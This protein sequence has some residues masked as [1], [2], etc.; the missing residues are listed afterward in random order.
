MN[1]VT[2][3]RDLRGDILGCSA[4]VEALL[5]YPAGTL[6]GT[7][8]LRLIP[9]DLRPEEAQAE[10][11]LRAG[12]TLPPT[13]SHR[14]S[15]TGERVAIYLARSAV[16]DHTGA[17]VGIADTL[18][19]LNGARRPQPVAAAR[20]SAPPTDRTSASAPIDSD[21]PLRPAPAAAR[22]GLWEWDLATDRMHW[23]PDCLALLEQQTAA[24]DTDAFLPAVHPDDRL[25]LRQALERALVDRSDL[26]V[27]FRL[28]LPDGRVRW[29]EGVGRLSCG[30]DGLPGRMVGTVRDI[31]AEHARQQ[32]VADSE[33]WFRQLAEGLPQITFAL[34]DR[35]EVSFVS[36]RGLEY[37]GYPS[38]VELG[39]AWNETVHPEDLPGVEARRAD[40]IG[41]GAR[42][43]M[44]Y[45]SRRSDGAYRWFDLRCTPIRSSAGVV[46][47]WFGSLTDIHDARQAEE[48]NRQAEQ[49]RA[50]VAAVSPGAI[51]S[52]RHGT[53]GR[54]SFPYVSAAIS[55]LFGFTPE[56][57][58]ADGAQVFERFLRKMFPRS[59]RASRP[60]PGR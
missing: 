33:A 10:R 8:A 40:A 49:R 13:T 54:L 5:G 60:P 46:E 9:T 14:L 25:V 47:R 50:K 26:R 52:F 28:L 1:D 55:R 34:D 20:P 38:E 45:R 53:D 16:R 23:S 7:P 11:R 48:Q 2:L 37:F 12:D 57:L 31:T 24:R 29:L 42:W 6:P 43:D 41:R 30:E 32:E 21:T 51:Y 39:P 58:R 44:V 35:G 56:E 27:E 18:T 17:L 3:L 19:P 4:G 36:R 15:R 22:M 59:S